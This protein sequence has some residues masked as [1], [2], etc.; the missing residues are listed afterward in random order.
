MH[1]HIIHSSPYANSHG[2]EGNH[3]GAGSLYFF[4]PYMLKAE[5]CVCLGSG[6]GFVPKLMVEAQRALSNDG[7]LKN[8]KVYLV[9][10]NIGP[11]GRPEYEDEIDGYPEIVVI[12]KLTN[13]AVNMFDSINY[14]HVDADHSYDQVLSDLIYYG[15]KMAGDWAITIH[16]TDNN[17]DGDH[18]EIG[19]Y[20]AMRDFAESND[21]YWTNFSIGCGTGLITP[22]KEKKNGYKEMGIPF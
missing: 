13:D 18:P 16:D 9:D 17:E 15:S 19:S 5:V 22:K 7:I 12:K 21:L 1:N 2:A 3:L 14:L 4:I 11:W 10:A 8:H 20:W 6:A